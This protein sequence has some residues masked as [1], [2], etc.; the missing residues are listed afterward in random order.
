MGQWVH[1]CREKEIA[2]YNVIRTRNA[3]H[4]AFIPIDSLLSHVLR[5]CLGVEN[6]QP[7]HHV[8]LIFTEMRQVIC[9][10]IKWNLARKDK[11]VL[12]LPCNGNVST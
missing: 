4:S 7:L 5:H 1:I 9:C 6:V 10:D 12:V 2:K 8:L 3:I 11:R